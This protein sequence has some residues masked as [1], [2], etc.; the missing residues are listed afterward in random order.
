MRDKAS[1]ISLHRDLSFAACCALP[2]VK[3]N[4]FSSVN[5]V[6]RQVVLGQPCFLFPGDVNLRSVLGM[7]SWHILRTWQ[8]HRIRQ[9]LISRATLLLFLFLCSSPFEIFL[10]QKMRHILLKHPLWKVSI[11]YHLSLLASIRLHTAELV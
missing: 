4:S 11:L 9:R 1:T 7:R 8:S 10:G 6:C 3:P 2:N 5:T